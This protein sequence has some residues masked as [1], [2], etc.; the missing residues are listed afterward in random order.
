MLPGAPVTYSGRLQRSPFVGSLCAAELIAPPI[1]LPSEYV[2]LRRCERHISAPV[3]MSLTQRYRLLADLAGA[4]KRHVPAISLTLVR[5]ASPSYSVPMPAELLQPDVLPVL[6][7]DALAPRLVAAGRSNIVA[8]ADDIRCDSYE[9]GANRISL[10][11][12][13]PS[14]DDVAAAFLAF[15]RSSPLPPCL[16]EVDIMPDATPDFPRSPTP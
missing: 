16:T 14:G 5:V 9:L 8:I 7:P 3:L 1:A 2:T 13:R 11:L 15:L 12:H 10:A 4:A 6:D